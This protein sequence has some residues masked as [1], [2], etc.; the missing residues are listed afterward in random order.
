MI[1]LF[2]LLL[3]EIPFGALPET[4]QRYEK[5]IDEEKNVF[6]CFSDQKEI[7][8]DKVNNGYPDCSDASDEPGTSTFVNH[9]FYCKNE[10]YVPEI[11]SSWLVSDGICDCCDGS[12]EFFNKHVTCP[13]TCESAEIDRK[14]L[15][16]KVINAYKDGI[17][18]HRERNLKGPTKMNIMKQR[19][20]E[21]EA[22]IAR[23]EEDIEKIENKTK[24]SKLAPPPSK[25]IEPTNAEKEKDKTNKEEKR[26][27][28][29]N[30][31]NSQKNSD[32]QHFEGS[33]E[34]QTTQESN[35]ENTKTKEPT[36]RAVFRLIWHFTFHVPETGTTISDRLNRKT[37]D[38]IKDKISKKKD[39][40][41]EFEG[42]SSFPN[43]TDLSFV[44]IYGEDSRKGDY[45]IEFL[46]E[47]KKDYQSIGKYNKTT[48]NIQ[49][50]TGGKH[51]SDSKEDAQTTVELV[52]WKRDKLASVDEVS[53]CR[54]HAVFGTPSVCTQESLKGL[55]K[56]PIGKLEDILSFFGMK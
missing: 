50:Y 15:F 29:E 3:F 8:L 33:S 53:E 45:K 7:S 11:I 17:D 21:I 20:A 9:T 38:D 49:Y 43:D 51:C 54:Y 42:I 10:G 34:P 12:D 5:S 14:M 13:N 28:E 47:I 48:G 26:E 46:K 35:E 39:E 16:R 6:R 37:I 18:L 2:Y 19:K 32:F 22:K 24:K 4:Y 56:L 31:E 40:L 27:N 44:P 55:E 25:T 36:W 30:S 23:F 41:K 1:L 52:C